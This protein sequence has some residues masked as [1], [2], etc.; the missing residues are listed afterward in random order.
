MDRL[1]TLFLCGD[2]MTGRGIDQVLPHPSNPV[3]YESYV[4]NAQDYVKLA[5]RANG[6][7]TQ[8]VD[9]AYIWG[10]VFSVM[11]K[12]D[13]RIINLETSIT[14][15]N[16]YI[17]KGINYRMHPDN[18]PCLTV[19][20]IDCCALANNHVLDW[21][22]EGLSETI[23]TLE[24]AGIE[25]AG[26]GR[27]L[28]DAEAPGIVPIT[29][30]GRVLVF[31]YGLSS[32]GISHDWKA[33]KNRSGINLLTDLSTDTI[34]HV[35]E[36]IEQFKQAGDLVVASIHWGGNWGYEIPEV[37]IELAHSLIDMAGADIIHGHSSHHLKG[38]EVYQ[39]KPIIYGCGD[40]LN[41]YEG[42]GGHESYRD[43]LG[44]LYLVRSDPSNG[45]FISMEMIPTQIKNFQIT[46]PTKR[47]RKWLRLVLNRE[48]KRFGT[49]VEWTDD[50]TLALAWN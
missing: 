1:L 13:A 49:N 8:P 26:A 36:V 14:K 9:F 25:Y 20:S 46:R 10:E 11:K 45:E 22:Q 18:L 44:L 50:R 35:G 5:E 19:A 32:S 27:N 12:A 48:G 29:G 31:S 37:Q 43:D 24:Q 28:A 47:D 3:L 7:I 4:K 23:E 15:S 39:G 30:K 33:T 42:I 16:N 17:N 41:D 38:L 34:L 40:F 6:P 2:I 21:G